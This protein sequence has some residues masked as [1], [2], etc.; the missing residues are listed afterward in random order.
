MGHFNE[1]I[2]DCCVC[3]M[4]CVLEQLVGIDN[5]AIVTPTFE[6]DGVIINQVKDFIAFTNRGNFPICQINAVATFDPN[7]PVNIK[8]IRK[9]KGECACCEDPITNLAKSM[10]GEIVE[11]EFISVGNFPIDEIINVGEGI[12]VGKNITVPN[13]TDF[14]SSCAITRITP[15]TQQQINNSSKAA[16]SHWIKKAT[17]PATL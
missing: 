4:Q 2:C 9:N 12:V 16:N 3:P 13:E 5:L 8:P 1:S 14:L 11:I 17:P 6:D 7:I 15:L 10:I